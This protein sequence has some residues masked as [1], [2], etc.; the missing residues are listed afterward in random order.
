[1][2]SN[3]HTATRRVRDQNNFRLSAALMAKWD[4]IILEGTDWRPSTCGED[5]GTGR[6]NQALSPRAEASVSRAAYAE[7]QGSAG[8]PVG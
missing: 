2:G 6:S 7:G 4:G 3:R 1:M 8:W 5:G